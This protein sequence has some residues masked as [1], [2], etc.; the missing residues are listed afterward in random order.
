MVG[1]IWTAALW[2]IAIGIT[3]TGRWAAPLRRLSQGLG[4]EHAAI[5]L[6]LLAFHSR[7]TRGG[8]EDSLASPF[9]AETIARGALAMAAML[10]LVPLFVPNARLAVVVRRRLWGVFGL[11]AYFV[12]AALSMLWSVFF[13]NTAGKVLEIGIAFAIAYVIAT[14]RDSVEAAKRS[15]MFVLY[16]EGF[17]IAVAISGFILV[18]GVFAQTLSRP[19]FFFQET[20]VAPFGGPN[21]FSAVGAMLASFALAHIFTLP[22]SANKAG[23]VGLLAMGSISTVLSSGRQGVIIWLVVISLLMFMF[24]RSL[25][26]FLIAPATAIFTLLNWETLWGIVSRDQV[27]G[28]LV[29]LTGRTNLWAAGVEAW[30]KQPLTGYGFGVGGRFVALRSI[31]LDFV[32]HLHN[33]FVE[34]L[35]GV[36]LL[37]FIPLMFV[38]L[39]TLSWSF[40]H[41]KRRVDVPFAILVLP[42]V[43]Q[44]FVGL[45]FGA[46]FNTNLMIFA[47]IVALA[48][49]MGVRPPRP[50]RR[51]LGTRLARARRYSSNV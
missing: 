39:R 29:T 32:I 13:L 48:D 43:M 16:L 27:S 18:P 10:I 8:A 26:L 23:W 49:A 34:A 21:G 14:R 3:R 15:L 25:F 42:L 51:P 36:G 24:R 1:L 40:R 35:V 19:G 12:V 28:S 7:A 2:V 20:M 31:D 33:G 11:G 47:L 5:V 22:R 38:V 9:V 37:G 45:G 17:L 6:L 44:N 30:T 46:W 50:A 4:R 41:L